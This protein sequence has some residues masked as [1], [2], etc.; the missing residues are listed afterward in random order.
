MQQEFIVSQSGGQKSDIKVSARPQSLWRCCF[1]L[2]LA[3][4]SLRDFLDCRQSSSPCVSSHCLS[5]AY[6]YLCVQIY[7]D[8]QLCCLR[9]H[10]NHLV[11]TRLPL[12]RLYFHISSHCEVL[13]SMTSTYLFWKGTQ[14][15]SEQ[16]KG[17]QSLTETLSASS[18]PNWCPMPC[19]WKVWEEKRQKKKFGKECTQ[20]TA[21]WRSITCIS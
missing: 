8:T 1:R 15:N 20:Y 16:K 2:L 9:A 10:S 4:D 17:Q 6:V 5:F 11:S 7:M 12:L 18:K 13:G 21:S 19:P 3:S 14:F